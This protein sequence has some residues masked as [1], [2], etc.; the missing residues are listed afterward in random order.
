MKRRPPIVVALVLTLALAATAPVSAKE[1]LRGDVEIDFNVGVVTGEGCCPTVFTPG[2]WDVEEWG[3]AWFGTVDMGGGTYWIVFDDG[4]YLPTGAAVHW[5]ERMRIYRHL[6][7]TI[8]NGVLTDM[9]PEGLLI[10]A[11]VRGLMAPIGGGPVNG[12]VTAAHDE[13][14][15]WEGRHIHMTG[16]VTGVYTE[17][18]YAEM[19]LPK[20]AFMALRIN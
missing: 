4:P 18:P 1:P 8:D 6:D 13:F 17:G 2:T 20:T 10:D 7:Y 9:V 19:E 11:I 12:L 5:V 16:R 14:A 3:V 15:E